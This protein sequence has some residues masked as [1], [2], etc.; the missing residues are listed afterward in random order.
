MKHGSGKIYCQSTNK[1][2][3]EGEW[4]DNIPYKNKGGNSDLI[5]FYHRT[6]IKIFE[7]TIKKAEDG[8]FEGNCTLYIYD[9]TNAILYRGNYRAPTLSTIMFVHWEME[10]Q[11]HQPFIKNF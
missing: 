8:W 11:D 1:V 9:D 10:L 4:R 6:G 3:F 2:I 5:T 7:G